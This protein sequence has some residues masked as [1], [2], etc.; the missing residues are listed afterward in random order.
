[1]DICNYADDTTIYTS[2]KNMRDITYRL[3]HDCSVALEW[4]SDNFMKSNA[5]KCH[6]FVL[7]QRSDDPVT[8]RIGNSK[9]VNSS[10]E[11]LLGVQIDNKLSCDNDVS[12]LCQKASNKL[13]ALAPI[14]PYMDQSKLR[15]VMTAFITSRFQHCPLIWMFHSRQL[16]KKINPISTG[17][18]FTYF[19]WGPSFSSKLQ[20]TLQ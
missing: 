9:V 14:S 4:F 6:L 7:G 17:R 12:K 8:A 20:K 19:D 16:N 3:E 10:E 18:F 1:M 5:D 2:D 11:K 15:T 13:Y